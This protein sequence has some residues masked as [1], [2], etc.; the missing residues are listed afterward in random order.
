MPSKSLNSKS[1]TN[2]KSLGVLVLVVI[3]ILFLFSIFKNTKEFMTNPDWVQ[4]ANNYKDVFGG[5]QN[6]DAGYPAGPLPLPEG[7]MLIFADNIAKPEC[8]GTYSTS[9]GYVCTTKAQRD[10]LNQRGGNRTYCID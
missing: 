1:F 8:R 10:F 7:E 5:N 2:F 3:V 4:S 6:A 9:D